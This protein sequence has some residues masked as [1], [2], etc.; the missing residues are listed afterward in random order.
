VLMLLLIKFTKIK[1]TI[2]NY[3]RNI[4]ITKS[5]L[6]IQKDGIMKNSD[7]IHND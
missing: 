6:V 7:V 3:T 4:M 1:R 2:S 5:Y